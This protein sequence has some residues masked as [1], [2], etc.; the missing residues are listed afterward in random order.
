MASSSHAHGSST[1]A[2]QAH[3][4]HGSTGAAH[5]VHATGAHSAGHGDGHAAERSGW[6]LIP[7]LVGLLVAAVILGLVG[8]RSDAPERTTPIGA[9]QEDV[10]RRE[11]G[12]V[13]E[14]GH[15]G[16]A[17]GHDAGAG[18]EEPAGEGDAGH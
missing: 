11:A 18:G 9:E 1:A 8:I 15:G 7:L 13:G 5:D 16:E 12:M 2:H 4:V 6:V 17:E 3:G 10:E 14:D